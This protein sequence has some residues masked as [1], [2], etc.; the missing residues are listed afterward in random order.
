[1]KKPLV[2][3]SGLLCDES[4]WDHQIKN[5]SDS[6]LIKVVCPNR[7][8]P[9]KM[10]EE[11]LERSPDRFSLAGH[12]MGGWLCL[13]TMRRAPE[14]VVRLCLL[15]TTAKP[16]TSAKKAKRMEMIRRVESGQFLEIVE[17]TV[18]D[19]VYKATIKS[20]V[21]RMMKKVGEEA[22]IRQERS[23]LERVE[24]F[25]LLPTIRCPV[26]VIHAKEDRIFTL[27]DHLELTENISGAQLSILDDC[28]H[29]SPMEKPE[30]VTS[31]LHSWL[32]M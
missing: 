21:E 7:D 4:V 13:E 14:R 6:A 16:D 29:M 26:L 27:E 30:A 19:F 9:Q 3:V 32:K 28:G 18:N 2:L 8:T 10:V 5:L 17:E 31:L 24:C 1:M 12:S 25:S 23:M 20:D 22:F 15:N 11:I